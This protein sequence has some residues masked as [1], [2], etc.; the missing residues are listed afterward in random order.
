VVALWSSV[1]PANNTF[2]WGDLDAQVDAA[3]GGGRRQVLVMVRNNPAWAAASR[4]KVTTGRE[5]ENL[6]GF[7][8]ALVNRYKDRV[9]YW[10]LYNEVDNTSEAFDRQYDL[11]GCF[12]T[13]DGG[14]PTQAGRDD[15]A[16]MLEVVGAAIHDADSD[17]K[18][19]SGAVTNGGF[20][21]PAC[22]TCLF[23]D[24]FAQGMLN[25]LR[26]EGALD[27]LDVVALHYYSSQ[28]AFSAAYGPDL[29]GSVEKLRQEMRDVGFRGRRLKSIIVD[30]GSYTG[31]VGKSTSDPADGFNRAQ[32][33]YVVKALVRAAAADVIYFWFSLRDIVGGGLGTDNAYGLLAVD[34]KPKPS[35]A[36]FTYFTSL[37]G[38][39]D[40][41]VARVDPQ[42]PKL[43]AYEFGLSDGR[44][45][46]IVWNSVDGER[47]AYRVD[48]GRAI[49]VS[50]PVG[51]QISTAGGIVVGDEPRFI[52]FR[53]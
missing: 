46:Q 43:E 23:D 7:L 12:G 52:F 35:Y 40:R 31:T 47:I 22:P 38:D 48:G 8:T 27:Q 29:L 26:H 50:D 16:R 34:G 33:D 5:R 28:H 21:G 3:S 49:G 10:Q 4:C 42:S 9:H 45:L 6:A 24:D 15:Y 2:N 36:A 13:A 39:G 20:V 11:G 53:R 25:S 51:T 44:R 41:A 18:V 32:R 19:V 17:A 14:R 30:E 1:E 37:V